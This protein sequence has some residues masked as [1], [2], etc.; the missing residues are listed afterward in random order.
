MDSARSHDFTFNEAVSLI[1]NCK[2]QDEI[3]YYWEKLSA[4]PDSEQCGWLKDQFGV[5]WQIVP[6]NMNELM[7]RD[8]EKVTPVILAMKK[9]IIADIITAAEEN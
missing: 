3:D 1:V 5:S 8:M 4:V 9:I 2:D 6:E 7:E